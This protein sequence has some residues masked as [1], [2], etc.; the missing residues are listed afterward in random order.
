MPLQVIRQDITKVTADAI[1]NTANPNPTYGG[2]TDKA[3]YEAAGMDELLEARKKIGRICPGDVSVTPAFKLKAKYIIHTVG[4]IWLDGNNGEFETLRSCYRKSLEKALDLQCKSIAF[5]LISTGVYGFPADKALKIAMSIMQEWVLEHDMLVYLVVFNAE[6][7]EL[8]KLIF[9]EVKAYV[10][11]NYVA[12]LS[13]REYYG[14]RG[15]LQKR[16]KAFDVMEEFTKAS[17]EKTG[18]KTFQQKLF[19]LQDARNIKNSTMYNEAFLSR[20]A[21]SDIQKKVDYQ[22]KKNT[23]I[24]FCLIM[25]LSLAETEDLLSRAGYVL[26]PSSEADRLV[27]KCISYGIYDID[28]IDEYL[29]DLKLD[30]LR[31]YDDKHPKLK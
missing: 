2:G 30:T 21:Y 17:G 24:L 6:A 10:A 22:P 5:P 23:A 28:L 14:E 19:E 15:R 13:D 4:P 12:E 26:N 8:S 27:E 25:K 9:G 7:T 20:A 11:E 31:K 16:T 1:V 29:T 18:E 3:L